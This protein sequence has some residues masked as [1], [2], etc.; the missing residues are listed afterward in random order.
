[1]SPF[2]QNQG[3]VLRALNVERDVI[4]GY[5]KRSGYTTFLGTPDNA[6]V[7]TLFN[8]V[9]NDG[10]TNT[11]YRASGS[12]LYHSVSGTGDWTLS[13]GG[14]IADGGHFGYAV[15]DNDLIGGDGTTAT[16]HST[17]G[18]SFSDV[19]GAPLA[20][21]WVDYQFR[22]WA[23]RGTAVSGTNTDMFYSTV[24]TVTDWTTDASS[25]R[26]TGAGRVNS[27]FK[28]ADRVMVSKDAG[29]MFRWDGYSLIDLSTN[30][31]PSSP[32]SIG[33]IEDFK[34]YLTRQGYYGYGGGKA[35]LISSPI[36]K[37]IYNRAGSGITG[38]TFDNAPGIGFKYNYYC[39]TGTVTDDLI[40]VTIPDNIHVYNFQL[41]EWY[42][43]QFANRPTAFGTYQ[44]TDSNEQMIFGDATGQCYQVTGTA[45]SDN[46]N[47]IEAQLMGFIHGGILEDKKW[48]WI[49]A[50]FSPGCRAKLSVALADTFTSDLN[51]HEVGDAV[52][53]VVEYRFPSG[54]RGK[55]CF[56]K[57]SENSTSPAWQLYAIEFDA[58]E[59]AHE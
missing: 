24:G 11:V 59:I 28:S 57:I 7:N 3:A 22:A 38:T 42:N 31:A 4:G 27:L 56:W 55:F 16:R 2:L 49:S 34:I 46:G 35:T 26:I 54:S 33:D 20:E 13:P 10:V 39:S 19:S 45:T 17:N 15:V 51:W 52:D 1:M 58:V 21:H 48:N 47:P 36:E 30:T 9:Q 6:Q 14:T 53:G 50:M 25:I 37:Q 43:W 44:D 8:W 18:T 12:A 41:D 29:N 5:R 32:Y 23:A 40:N